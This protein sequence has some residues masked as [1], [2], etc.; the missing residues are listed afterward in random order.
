MVIDRGF[1]HHREKFCKVYA[2]NII[3]TY[4]LMLMT[5]RHSVRRPQ[6]VAE[7][8]RAGIILDVRGVAIVG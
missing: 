5:Y 2:Q 3:I 8:V 6:K 7:S 1:S 4:S